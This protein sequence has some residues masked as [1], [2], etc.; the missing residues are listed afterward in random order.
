MNEVGDAIDA[1]ADLV[2]ARPARLTDDAGD[3][4]CEPGWSWAFADMGDY[5]LWA[6]AAGHGHAVI[7]DQ[8]VPLSPGTVLLLR[9]WSSGTVEQDADQRLSV[10]YCHFAFTA[11]P[12]GDGSQG[13][14]GDT[15]GIPSPPLVARLAPGDTVLNYLAA[16]VHLLGIPG[17][18]AHL[19][20]E[21][22]LQLVLLELWQRGRDS[23]RGP[24]RRVV[25][26][27]AAVRREPS[28]RWALG[29][30]ATASHLSAQHFSR[31]FTTEAGRSFRSFVL[32]ARMNRARQL[33]V[34][35]PMTVSQISRALGYP[36][37]HLFS[38]QIRA[39]FGV[40]PTTMRAR[41][42]VE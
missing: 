11:A 13:P 34:E 29:D 14:P 24:D 36:D 9:P 41:G 23:H 21:T 18:L 38:R 3:V 35:T 31:L 16:L 1:F 39:H 5:D 20:R 26:A 40:P 6:V 19:R 27:M 8:S 17:P 42:R 28:R 33:L 10:Q 37:V 30:A 2:T 32:E 22:L 12:G 7:D 15:S 25:E 4:T